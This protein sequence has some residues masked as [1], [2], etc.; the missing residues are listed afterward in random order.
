VPFETLTRV[1]PR[2]HVV[3][4]GWIPG[5]KRTVLGGVLWPVVEYS[6]Y[7]ACCRCFQPYS[8]GGS[9]DAALHCQYCSNLFSPFGLSGNILATTTWYALEAQYMA[10]VLTHSFYSFNVS[11]DGVSMRECS[12]SYSCVNIHR[13]SMRV[14]QRCQW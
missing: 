1:G 9:S 10:T 5:G 4:R 7:P 2:N 14:I 8:V 11:V 3:G 6:E 13:D 12:Y